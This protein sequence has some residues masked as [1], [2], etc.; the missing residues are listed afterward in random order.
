M[1]GADRTAGDRLR[2]FMRHLGRCKISLGDVRTK[3]RSEVGVPHARFPPKIAQSC[4]LACDE[5]RALCM[6]QLPGVACA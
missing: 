3:P 6:F 1:D 5:A 2:R 4:L